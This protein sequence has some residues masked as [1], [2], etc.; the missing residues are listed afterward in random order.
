MS[1]ENLVN[2]TY[3][4]TEITM[5]QLQFYYVKS[6]VVQACIGNHFLFY[7]GMSYQSIT[8]ERMT[9]DTV[10]DLAR[11]SKVRGSPQR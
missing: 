1:C 5:W 8:G 4:Q 9:I 2:N 10:W 7:K 11:P 3:T 6:F